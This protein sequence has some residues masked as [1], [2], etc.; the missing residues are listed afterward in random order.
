MSDIDLSDFDFDISDAGS[1]VDEEIQDLDEREYDRLATNQA[2]CNL[3]A[4][5]AIPSPWSSAL[6]EIPKSFEKYKPELA[7]PAKPEK[8]PKT[9]EQ[10]FCTIFSPGVINKIIKHTNEEILLA[11]MEKKYARYPLQPTDA[12]EIER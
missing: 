7:S 9:E 10:I 6:S 11:K 8:D 5:D 12:D 4:Y 1:E 2:A 3:K